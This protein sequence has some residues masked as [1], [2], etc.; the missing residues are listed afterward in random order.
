MNFWIKSYC[1]QLKE[2]IDFRVQKRDPKLM[3]AHRELQFPRCCDITK[4]KKLSW[5]FKPIQISS[6]TLRLSANQKPWDKSDWSNKSKYPTE[7]WSYKV[8]LFNILYLFRT[9]CYC[10][11]MGPEPVIYWEYH[12]NIKTCDSQWP[13]FKGYLNK[14]IVFRG[15][16][17]SM[18]L[19]TRFSFPAGRVCS[20]FDMAVITWE[21]GTL[22][23]VLYQHLLVEWLLRFLIEVVSFEAS[24]FVTFP[25]GILKNPRNSVL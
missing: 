8:I 12:N 2:L 11:P 18:L 17:F 1:P 9:N 25:T 14:S 23:S 6:R 15:H 24:D 21:E 10:I 4:F 20:R 16:P 19:G 13:K 5:G 7:L 22:G 3:I